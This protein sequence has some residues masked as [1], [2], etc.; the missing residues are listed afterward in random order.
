MCV[1]VVLPGARQPHTWC[2]SSRVFAVGNVFGRGR[3]SSGGYLVG[4]WEVLSVPGGS[5]G[6]FGAFLEALEGS[7]VNAVK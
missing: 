4:P 1:V 5:W 6:S 3:D 2:S 7:A